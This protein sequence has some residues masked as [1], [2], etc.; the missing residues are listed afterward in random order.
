MAFVMSI[1]ANVLAKSAPDNHLQASWVTYQQRYI[2]AQG[3]I[4]DVY[5]DSASHSEGQAYGL[6]LALAF[7]D[8]TLFQH[9]WIWTQTHLQ[10][11]ENDKLLAWLWSA[12]DNKQGRF[13]LTDKNNATDADI[14]MAY[15][16][17]QASKKWNNAHY[18]Q[19][20]LAMIADI[21]RILSVTMDQ[22]LFLLAGEKGFYQKTDDKVNIAFNPSYQFIDFFHVFS[23]LDDQFFWRKVANNARYHLQQSYHNRHQLPPEWLQVENKKYRLDNNK[24]IEMSYGAYR[25]FLYESWNKKPEYPQGLDYLLTFYQQQGYL[26]QRIDLINGDASKEAASA[27]IYAV[28]ALA[29]EKNGQ[30]QLAKNIQ[31]QAWQ[32]IKKE[33][34]D[35][36]SHSLFLLALLSQEYVF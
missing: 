6:L 24:S 21:R 9:I 2:T 22:R 11:R 13:S 27:G 4:I 34:D 17:Y 29:A 12:K 32:K 25:V 31:Q 5:Q 36:Y 35:Y 10:V 8:E 33:Q 16:L 28:L 1:C 15:V 7:D 14:L 19:Q 20:S 18:L 3:R 30:Q 23:T 26:P